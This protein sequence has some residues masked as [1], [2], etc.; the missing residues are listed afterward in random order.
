MTSYT[1][2]RNPIVSLKNSKL[3]FSSPSAT[4][5]LRVLDDV[6]LKIY[7]GEFVT[8]IGPSGCGKSTLL[9]ILAGLLSPDSGLCHWQDGIFEN[10]AMEMAMNFQTPVLLPWLTVEENALL[11]FHFQK[12]LNN[13]S[14][15]EVESRL[16]NLLELTNLIYFRRAFPR[17]LSGG[18]Q[19][20]AAL[21]RT[22]IVKPKLIFMDEPFAAIDELTRHDLGREFRN[23]ARTTNA[24]T[25]FVTHSIQEAAFLSDRIIIMSPRPSRIVEEITV[26]FDQDEPRTEKLKRDRRFLDLCDQLRGVM[27]HS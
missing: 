19:M 3:M 20:R 26:P 4:H 7:S 21:I 23:I 25:V 24:A 13:L 18:M 17:E 12:T 1:P 14:G 2:S 15:E 6:S 27:T 9:R 8:I 11:P 5:P 10:R 16:K 22:L